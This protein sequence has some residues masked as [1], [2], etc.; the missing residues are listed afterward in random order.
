MWTKRNVHAPKSEPLG[1]TISLWMDA[2]VGVCVLFIHNLDE[3]SPDHDAPK[4]SNRLTGPARPRL[5]WAFSCRLFSQLARSLAPPPL[6]LQLLSAGLRHRH[7]HRHRHRP[8]ISAYTSFRH[9]HHRHHQHRQQ[10]N[11]ASSFSLLV[12]IA[13]PASADHAFTLAWGNGCNVA[14]TA[15]AGAS[16][17]GRFALQRPLFSPSSFSDGRTVQGDHCR[18]LRADQGFSFFLQRRPVIRFWD[19]FL[20]AVFVLVGL[21]LRLGSLM[22]A[23]WFSW[24]SVILLRIRGGTFPSFRTVVS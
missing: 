17:H 18:R 10:Y 12:P 3:V 23:A 1:W 20:C 19:S 16:L 14:N 15:A 6:M 13:S 9:G 8:R 11:R 21:G 22:A 5:R 2:Y 24:T 7:R 4:E